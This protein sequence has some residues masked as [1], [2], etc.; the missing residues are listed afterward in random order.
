MLLFKVLILSIISVLS[1]DEC[2][3]KPL[4]YNTEYHAFTSLTRMN[5]A[6][7]PPNDATNYVGYQHQI[8]GANEN[9]TIYVLGGIYK[10]MDITP[11]PYNWM[12]KIN[13]YDSFLSY[14]NT[15]DQN[16]LSLVQ[17]YWSIKYSNVK[18][19][20]VTGTDGYSCGDGDCSTY[21]NN[22]LYVI[23]PEIFRS[24]IWT[25]PNHPKILKFNMDES[26]EEWI[27]ETNYS[28]NLPYNY[29]MSCL[30]AASLSAK[31]SCINLI[32]DTDQFDTL[33]LA[34]DGCTTHNFTHIFHFNWAVAEP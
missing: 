20:V 30:N 2:E 32:N 29:Y 5:Y 9:G 26:I 13:V 25:G 22:I 21:L 1:D 15:V 27:P 14:D 16:N 6:G 17:S 8:I 7:D 23:N 3:F 10:Y 4:E 24:S 11:Y 12:N 18:P 33:S 19:S 31:L 34:G 28:S